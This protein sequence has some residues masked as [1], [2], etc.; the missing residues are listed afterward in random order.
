[1]T[2][3]I[4]DPVR[5]VALAAREIADRNVCFVGIGVPSLAAITAKAVHAPD[6]VLIYESGAIDC[7]PPVPP[8]STGSPSVVANTAMVTTC[9]GVFSMLQKGE[10][11][12]GLL[13]AAQVDRYGNLNS[14][15]LG[16]YDAPKVRLVGSG[17]AHDIAVLAR[18]IVI[19][20]PHD[21]RRF[22]SRV[23]FSTS[24]G[25]HTARNGLADLAAR[26]GG[27]RC[28]IT[29][30]AR[31]TFEAGEMTLDAVADGIDEAAAVEG[32]GWD[33]P[34][35]RTVRRLAPIEPALTVAAS[36]ILKRWGREAN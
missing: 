33:V 4:A 17:G 15:V 6:A 11:D 27:P 22:V 7:E 25:I 26:G 12:L 19:L 35:G 10:F 2:D 23:D 30:R 18:E 3:P 32:I 24:P 9:L 20:M 1:M 5:F 13:S 29:P 14:T 31:F 28:V 8:L 36:D 21:P 34:R 16:P